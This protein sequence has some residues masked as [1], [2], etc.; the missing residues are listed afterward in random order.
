M[1]YVGWIIINGSIATDKFLDYANMIKE[2]AVKQGI[3]TICLK[4]DDVITL[5]CPK[6]SVVSSVADNSKLPDFA[7]F[8]D[9]DIYLAR[10]L[11][12]LG[13]RVFN[14][15]K[16]IEISDDKIYTYQMLEKYRLPIPKTIIAPKKY[17]AESLSS[18]Y[19][20]KII[21]HLGFPLIVKEAFG[22]FGQQ[23]H[24]IHDIK[25]LTSTISLIEQRPFLF[26]TY[27]EESKGRDI[28][29]Q[30]IGNKAITAVERRNSQ[31]FRAN[32]TNGGKMLPFTI[33][34]EIENLAVTAVKAI[35]AD[36][37]GVDLLF[38]SNNEFLICEINANAHIRNL[39]ECT[40]VNSADHMI[41]YMQK[42]LSQ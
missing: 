33:N 36:F 13:V 27:I 29:V 26:Q 40:G 12:Q 31:D 30:V 8:I 15:S 23:V 10:Q 39:Y 16:A 35:G 17:H 19:I 24:L 1:N 9:K 14:S 42:E 37:A 4:N 3:T 5:L 7:F 25:E 32:V 11:E 18:N 21:D 2:A 41:A 28:R 20:Q 6:K 22:S 38:G 34:D